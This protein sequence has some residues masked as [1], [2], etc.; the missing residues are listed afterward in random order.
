MLSGYPAGE[1]PTRRAAGQAWARAAATASLS[2][3]S[4]RALWACSAPV[5]WPLTQ[6]Q[7]TSAWRAISASSAMTRSW[8]LTGAPAAVF[9][10]FFFQPWIHLVMESRR[11]VESVTMQT[12]APAASDRSPSRAAVYSMRLLV[13]WPS[14]P[15]S[16]TGSAPSGPT[17]IAA[18]P[19][20]PG[21]PLQ[22]PSVHTSASPG[23]AWTGTSGARGALGR[24]RRY[25][26]AEEGMRRA[27]VG[28]GQDAIGPPQVGSGGSSRRQ[29]IHTTTQTAVAQFIPTVRRRQA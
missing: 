19:P 21:L 14:P 7:R 17:T 16:S 12:V 26:G 24:R 2:A 11:S 5:S 8:F 28:G 20:G 10:P 4:L 22:A 1:P 27:M 3:R 13:V 29:A 6:C 25:G 9:Q 15:D 23:R 18:Q